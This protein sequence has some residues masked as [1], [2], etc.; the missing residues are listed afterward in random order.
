M[1]KILLLILSL[2][3]VSYFFMQEQTFDN[4]T[5][6]IGGSLPKTSILKEYGNAVQNGA[7]AYFS[8]A[9][10][11]NMIPNKKIKFITYDDKYE[12]KLTLKNTKRLLE[13]KELFV[14]Y[15]FVGTPTVKNVLPLIYK[16]NIPFIAPFSGATFLRNNTN[17]NIIN[18]RSSYKKEIQ[19]HIQY[20]YEKKGFTKIA[21]F[22]QNDEYGEDG[23]ISLVNILKTYD[24]S[25]IAEGN[26]K[27]NT[28]SIRHA[29]N[30][31]K[32]AK[33]E[34]IIMIGANKAN[35]LFIKKAQQ[36]K[37]FNDTIFCNIS[38]GDASEMIKDLGDDNQNILFSQ[39]VPNYQDKSLPI[40]QEYHTLTK[41]Y[42]PN[43][44]ASFISFEAFLSAKLLVTAIKN[45]QGDITRKKFLNQ[46]RSLPKETLKGI[47]IDTKNENF[48]HKVY[49]FTYKNQHFIEVQK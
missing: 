33:P 41:Q 44:E 19:E 39:I 28:L 36:N 26:Y 25:L 15:G 11:T 22:Y 31:I 12:P 34:A 42:D 35:T 24:L 38:F 9:N 45:I 20:L 32:E 10:K 1:K 4:D 48:L 43:F 49:L 21:V 30:S 27:R 7:N 23:Y 8:Y 6:L 2:F 18:F 17:K 29:F 5:I 3:T 40:V 13:N 47:P 14:L 46:L 37:D 16:R